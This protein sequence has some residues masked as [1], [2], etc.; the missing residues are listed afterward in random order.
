MT[1]PHHTTFLSYGHAAVQLAATLLGREPHD[2]D[3][4]EL[5]QHRRKL[6]LARAAAVALLVQRRPR[7]CAGV[8]SGR[9]ASRN[10]R[11]SVSFVYRR[12]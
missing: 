9:P 2:L 3:G 5:Q 1:T 7:G 12:W 4:A 10:A 6:R 11:P 8:S